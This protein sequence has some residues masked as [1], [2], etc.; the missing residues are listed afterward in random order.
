MRQTTGGGDGG[1]KLPF[2]FLFVMIIA[3]CGAMVYFYQRLL[4]KT[5]L[6]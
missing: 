1:W 2:M 4:R 6:P 5:H 3:A